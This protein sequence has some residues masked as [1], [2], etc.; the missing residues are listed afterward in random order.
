MMHTTAKP[1]F[2]AAEDAAPSRPTTAGD[3]RPPCRADERLF[4][5]RGVNEPPPSVLNIPVIE[6]IA[7]LASQHTLR[8]TTSYGSGLR[9]FHIFCDV[10]SIPEAERLPASF[11][12]IHSFAL[13]AAADPGASDLG[14]E[15]ASTH[16]EPVSP[17]TVD[18]YL[19]AVRAWH[20]AQGWEDPL[21]PDE[22]NR[23]SRSL[24]GLANLQGDRKSTRLN[25]SHS[26]ESRMPSSA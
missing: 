24:R 6:R 1:D 10:F 9:K 26:G 23:I 22:K 17:A 7:S 15:F 5:W 12:L 20:L 16:F 11:P 14:S 3:L 21:S 4:L 13:W 8:D 2:T 18:K 25:S 19:S